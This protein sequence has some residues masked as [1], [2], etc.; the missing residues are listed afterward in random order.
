MEIFREFSFEAA[1]WLPDV[2]KGH[3]CSRLHGHSYRVIVTCE[4]PVT[5]PAG[6][7]IDF[8]QV[9]VAMD[10]PLELLDHQALN[11]VPGLENPTCEHLATWIW[12]VLIGVLPLSAVTVWETAHA[13][14]T[15]RGPS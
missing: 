2:P 14:C 7:V 12:N 13:G 10:R 15:Y 4:G 5:E 11:D 8:G 3:K 6:W 1:H 9:K